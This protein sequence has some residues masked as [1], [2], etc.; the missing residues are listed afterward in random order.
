MQDKDMSSRER[1]KVWLEQSKY[2]LQAAV[3]SD[4]NANYEWSC[5]QSIQSVEKSLKAIVVHSGFRPPKTHKLGVLVS[6]CNRANPEFFNV[7]LYFRKI[8]SYTFISRYPFVIPGQ[9][10]TPHELIS[11]E[12]AQTCLDIAQD[13][14]KKVEDFLIHKKVDTE[15][16]DFPE[17][18]YTEQEIDERIEE[19]RQ[20]IVASDQLEVKKIIL[21]GSFARE[22]TRPKSSTMD[23]LV[24]ADTQLPFIQRIEHIRYVTKGREP[25][26]EPLVYT[27]DEFEYMHE[28]QGEGFIESAIEEGKVIYD[29][30]P[31]PEPSSPTNL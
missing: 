1:F 16:K 26:I 14:Y 18:Y 2:D 9:N 12:D 20:Q 30:N 7:K 3:K 25:I 31:K 27:P 23:V 28:E 4:E 8:E 6:M 11:K 24:V 17:F 5:Y 15:T 10:K 13:I 21:F 29:V 19:I 22:N